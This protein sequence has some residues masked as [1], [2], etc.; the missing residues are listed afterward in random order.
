MRRFPDAPWPA[1]SA[2]KPITSYIMETVSVRGAPLFA[3]AIFY[4]G[5]DLEF[6]ETPQM[7]IY[8]P[9]HVNGNLF[10]GPAGSSPQSLTFHGPVTASG[11]VF[12]AWRGTTTTAQEGGSTMSATTAVNFSTDTTVG[13]NP[14]NMRIPSSG[15]W[16]DST[17][18]ND[19]STSGLAA[20]QAL[21]T[22]ARSATFSQ[23]ASQTWHGNLQTEAMGI[24]SYNPMGFSE[25]VGVDGSG[26]NILAT[27]AIADDGAN[28]GTGAGYGHGYGPH[29]LI[30]PSLA[31]PASTDPYV[32]AKAAIEEQ[33][34]ANKASLYLKV[35]V[36]PGTAG[37]AD[38]LTPTL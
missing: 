29:S 31:A 27:D 36:T 22:P 18:G 14:F 7:D 6:G 23:Y 32:T 2:G 19:S 13:G 20:L 15:I 16:K 21:V 8:G 17:D 1:G 10:V 24:Q 38:T 30:E 37:A 28:V 11:N 33:K 4:S 9:V 12:H 25:I 26:N 3:Y 35:V 5:N 34:F